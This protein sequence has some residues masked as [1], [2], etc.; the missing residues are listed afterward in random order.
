MHWVVDCV[1]VID[2]LPIKHVA[3]DD[4][5]IESLSYDR[6]SGRLEVAMKW[7]SIRQFWPVSPSL[8]RESE[9]DFGNS[10]DELRLIRFA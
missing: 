4:S 7:N 6:Y 3:I 1:H 10:R 9:P 8:F 5:C 2:P